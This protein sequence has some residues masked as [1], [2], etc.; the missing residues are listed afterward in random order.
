MKAGAAAANLAS[1]VGVITSVHQRIPRP[2]NIDETTCCPDSL[3][4]WTDALTP[5]QIQRVVTKEGFVKGATIGRI[6]SINVEG[7]ER[8]WTV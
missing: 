3:W 6:N 4:L 5:D 7:E 8:T 1:D 2:K